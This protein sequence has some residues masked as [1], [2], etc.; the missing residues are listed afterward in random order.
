MMLC[1]CAEVA[2]HASLVMY[3]E[4]NFEADGRS[5]RLIM[6][7]GYKLELLAE[8][9]KPRMMTVTD[10]DVLLVGSS[11]GKL[12]RLKPPYDTVAVAADLDGFPHSV[13]LRDGELF[14]A[15]TDGVY[16]APYD[17]DKLLTDDDFALVAALPGGGG[18]ASRSVAVGPDHRIYLGIGIS[19]NCSDQYIGAGY[20]FNRQRGG[21]LV[22]AEKEGQPLQWQPYAS[23]LRNPVGF[24]WHPSS[25]VLYVSNNGPDHHGYEL[26]PE[27]FS[28]VEAG[29]FHG[30]PWFWLGKN[31]RLL[32]DDCID[33]RPPRR[34]AQLPVATFP[35]RSA[36]MGVA[37][38]PPGSL[39]PEMVGSAVVAIHGSWAT[40]PR[41][42][43]W[44]DKATRRP[45]HIAL[46]HFV[47]E[48]AAEVFV[49]IEGFQDATGNRLARPMGIAF[50]ADGT[51]YFTSDGGA[52]EG[53]FRLSRAH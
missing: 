52:V 43:Y 14:V 37:F 39:P 6:L 23:G 20:S 21:I 35:A 50:T 41:G 34:D 44:G 18:H 49:L 7:S 10:D 12:Y 3:G 31:N 19:G 33:S 11:V 29:S 2:A 26:P 46:V 36:P 30:M 28:R 9:K 25:E 42:G 53:L 51:L 16:R 5:W 32:V 24:D 17:D 13:A 8:M 40:K 15:M 22:L 1:L 27:Y 47:K 45:P 48:Q 38:V 4:Q